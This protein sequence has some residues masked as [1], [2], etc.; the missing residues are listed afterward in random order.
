MILRQSRPRTLLAGWTGPFSPFTTTALGLKTMP[1]PPVPVWSSHQSMTS[2]RSVFIDGSIRR[3]VHECAL[4]VLGFKSEPVDPRLFSAQGC[5]SSRPVAL[6]YSFSEADLGR[7]VQ[8]FYHASYRNA[9]PPCC[10]LGNPNTLGW[11]RSLTHMKAYAL[12]RENA[13]CSCRHCIFG[14]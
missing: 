14:T 7:P 12:R 13:I 4:G 1:S 3:Q 8:H 11:G 10:R 6:R 9:G 5:H 2:L